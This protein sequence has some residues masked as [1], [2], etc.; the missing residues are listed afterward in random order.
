MIAENSSSNPAYPSQRKTEYM[1]TSDS[2]SWVTHSE[3]NLDQEN[4]STVGIVLVSTKYCPVFKCQSQSGSFTGRAADAK[5]ISMKRTTSSLRVD[6]IVFTKEFP[7]TCPSRSSRLSEGV[8][9]FTCSDITF[10][11]STTSLVST[12]E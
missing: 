4:M 7:S 6:S 8:V 3:P 12:G 10:L 5:I 11:K 1:I 9:V 2:H